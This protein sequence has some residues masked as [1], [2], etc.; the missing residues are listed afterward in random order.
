MG[1]VEKGVGFL[2][3]VVVVDADVGMNLEVVETVG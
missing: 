3:L 2:G 1:R